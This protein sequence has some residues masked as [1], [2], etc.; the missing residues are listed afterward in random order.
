MDI[1]RQAL[2]DKELNFLGKSYGTYLGTL[3]AQLFPTKVGHMV[4]DGAVD[5]NIS[6]YQQSLAQAVGFD[7]ALN[8]F[9]KDCATRD[10]C[11]LPTKKEAALTEIKSLFAQAKQSPLPRKKEKDGDDRLATESLLVVGTASALYDS[12]TGWPQLRKAIAEAQSGFGDTYLKLADEYSGRQRNGKYLNNEFDSGAVIDCLD[13]KDA[14]T[15]KQVKENES[16]FTKAAPIFGPYLAF[17]GINCNYIAKLPTT[18]HFKEITTANPIIVIGT[19]RDP[20]TPYKWAQ[21]LHGILTNSTLISLDGD[22][23]TAQGRGI[24][25][26]DDQVDAF[27]LDNKIPKTSTCN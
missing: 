5:P 21:G 20:A 1:L 23:H 3:Y 22:G 8:A 25:C 14:R 26:V 27:Y 24:P 10:R 12:E 11:P 15:L 19:T 17:S 6:T 9:I 7:T 2:G 16:V 18:K 4:L 13:F